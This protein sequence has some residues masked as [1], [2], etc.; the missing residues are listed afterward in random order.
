MPTEMGRLRVLLAFWATKKKVSMEA[1][2]TFDPHQQRR[3]QKVRDIKWD[4][5]MAGLERECFG[6]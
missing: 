4:N 5:F 6:L 1:F 2:L 3:C